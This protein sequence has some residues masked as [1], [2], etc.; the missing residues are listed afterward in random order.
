VQPLP[1]SNAAPAATPVLFLAYWYPPEN[2]SGAHRPARL[3]KYLERLGYAPG[4]IAAACKADPA[5]RDP[6]VRTR[7]DSRVSR[8]TA[9]AQRLVPYNDRI[10]WISDATAAASAA[11]TRHGARLVISTSPPVATHLSALLLRRQHSFAWVADFRDPIVGNPFRRRW[12]GRIY[13]RFVE[14]QVVRH[15]DA[16]LVNT[17]AALEGFARR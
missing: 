16:I 4:V 13:D 5:P 8:A 11:L 12:H 17:D 1:S 2:E 3:A 6:I 10:E 15:A 14:G 7:A 9:L